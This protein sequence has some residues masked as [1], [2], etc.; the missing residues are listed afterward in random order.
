[1][2][3]SADPHFEGLVALGHRAFTGLY[4]TL[5][6]SPSV[7]CSTW[8]HIK[9]N[10]CYVMD[11]TATRCHLWKIPSLC[12]LPIVIQD[13]SGHSGLIMSLTFHVHKMEKLKQIRGQPDV[14]L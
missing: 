7:L 4:K 9:C 14:W 1:M 12:G 8:A 13:G 6:V 5:E 3:S 10:G 2:D 11:R